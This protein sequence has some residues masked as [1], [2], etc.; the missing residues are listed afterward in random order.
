MDQRTKTLRLAAVLFGGGTLLT[1]GFM[2]FAPKLG[3]ALSLALGLPLGA[4]LG[5]FGYAFEEV[6]RA[7][8][9]A[10]AV[11]APAVVH[12]VPIV[13]RTG[14]QALRAIGR[15]LWTFFSRSRP[16]YALAGL[17]GFGIFVVMYL[18][19][20]S[21]LMPPTKISTEMLHVMIATTGIMTVVLG[22]VSNCLMSCFAIARRQNRDYWSLKLRVPHIHGQ[23]LNHLMNPFVE[24]SWR[25]GVLL[26]VHAATT[27]IWC[28]AMAIGYTLF[29]I[30]WTAWNAPGAIGRFAVALARIIYSDERVVCAVHVPMGAV[31]TYLGLRLHLEADALARLAAAELAGAALFGG[32]LTLVV[33]LVSYQL[34]SVRMLRA[35]PVARRR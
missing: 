28:I 10:A 14:G 19:S 35:A 16:L 33:G 11:A 9:R 17:N 24:L 18:A 4:A 3:L 30:G 23:L 27:A 5:Y 25:D 32:L 7:I 2:I 29:A 26:Y 21:P 6:L 34:I 13:L 22:M 8:P 20:R 1:L 15:G 31:A 12:A